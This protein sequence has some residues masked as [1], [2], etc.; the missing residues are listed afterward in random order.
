MADEEPDD[1]MS[2]YIRRFSQ[3]PG[4]VVLLQ[5]ESIDILDLQPPSAITGIGSGTVLVVG[6]FENGPFAPQFP[7]TEVF[8]PNNF[9]ST[10]GSLGYQYGAQVGQNPCARSRKADGAIAP[11]LWNGN[12][13]VQL[14]A[15]RF[16]RLL[17][18]RVNTS[19]GAV[20]VQRLAFLT[21]ANSFR[22]QLANGQVLQLDTGSGP[23]SATFSATAATVTGSGGTFPTTFTGGQT[24]VLAYDG[25]PNFTTTFLSGDQTA[26][27]VAARINQY[28][29]F[30]FVTLTG[31]QLTFTGLQSGTGGSVSIVSGSTGVLAQLG[32]T[33]GTTIGT[34]N[35]ANV[36]AVSPSEVALVV[37]AAISSS[38]VEVDQN[39]ALRISNT[40]ANDFLVVGSGT[41]AT[42]LGFVAGTAA[43]DL[44]EPILVS[45]A[46][47]YNLG[48]T[49]TVTLQ[50]DATLAQVTA[51]VTSGHS[52]AQTVTDL[53]T[54]FTAA[55]QGAPVTAD[56]ST[57]FYI[58]GITPGG[59]VSV[60][61][62]SAGGILRSSA[63]P[64]GP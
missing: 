46:G 11:E 54:A 49:G 45:G 34:G 32:L 4:N 23:Q 36:A 29:G 27:Q 19:V 2:M 3:D 51:T 39:G 58:E 26:A 13:F 24:L 64:S 15:K 12:G 55:G 52:L 7:A 37:Q 59:T 31:G 33:A 9:L 42:A 14:N 18:C 60:V 22:C 1:A 63:S 30:T 44:G 56:G 25:N 41:T 5:I 20:T 57:R 6:E 50:L 43:T 38:K 48:T 35:V 53:N 21:G 62:A 10:F 8:S 17:V 16:A 61:S 28:A 47:T 40:S